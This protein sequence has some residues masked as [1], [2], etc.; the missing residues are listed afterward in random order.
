[1]HAEELV[2]ARYRLD[3]RLAGGVMGE[4]WR[5]VDI[6]LDLA[7]AV[8][9]LHTG[10]SAGEEFRARFESEARTLAGLDAPSV[11][12]VRD[13]GV[14]ET[15]EGTRYYLV[16]ELVDGRPLAGLGILP[17]GET[18]RVLADAAEGLQA[19]HE[20]GIVHGGLAPAEVLITADGD[21]KLIG[22]GADRVAAY[23]APEL[24]GDPDPTPSADIY[25]LGA[26]G[27]ACLTGTPPF[28]S[29][30]P[31][32]VEHGHLN[33]P[34]PALPE[35]V[36]EALAE[37]VYRAL[38]KEPADRWLTA[39]SFGA[40]CRTVATAKPAVVE[41]AV[42]APEPAPEP[43]AVDKPEPTAIEAHVPD[44]TVAD[45]RPPAPAD[46]PARRRRR[47]PVL[48]LA[49]LVALIALA[50]AFVLPRLMDDGD[51]GTAGAAPSSGAPSDAASSSPGVAPTEEDDGAPGSADDR[52]GTPAGTTTGAESSG[53]AP[54]VEV[55]DLVGKQMSEAPEV[56][57]AEG[58]ESHE[59]I[60]E[61]SG[62]WIAACEIWAQT[63]E[64]G[65]R[66][67]AGTKVV[68]RYAPTLFGDCATRA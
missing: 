15:P 68:Y 46:E 36:P 14:E 30:D 18:A 52:P 58:F 45:T 60:S 43:E 65:A 66:V 34:P 48:V 40:A 37:A 57:E 25:A 2:G 56:L 41:Q 5:A 38:R 7:V 62:E 50:A 39:H 54:L 44:E 59:G 33:Q 8:K 21:V 24:F 17:F 63:P 16:L 23:S 22:F 3:T 28:G 35:D 47:A 9:L 6:R 49:A 53:A 67:E 51:P 13:H 32:A 19:A 26:I 31:A 64:A 27:F 61:R 11:A 29:G 12:T 4:V 20:A 1:M 42:A 55:P 10:V